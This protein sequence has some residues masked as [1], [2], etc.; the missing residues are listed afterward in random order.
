MSPEQQD[1]TIAEI[2]ASQGPMPSPR[3]LKS[4]VTATPAAQPEGPIEPDASLPS[5]PPVTTVR[6]NAD[7][8]DNDREILAS[9]ITALG[10]TSS[11]A[12][13]QELVADA[14]DRLPE[15]LRA[16]RRSILSPLVSQV[17]K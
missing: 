5:I 13:A 11:K 1:A 16:Y 15:G 4:P 6:G 8:G 3:N 10:S 14:I 9:V 2:V 17:K 7:L 12:R